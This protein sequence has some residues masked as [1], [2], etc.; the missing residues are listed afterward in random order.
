MRVKVL[1]RFELVLGAAI[2]AFNF[3]VFAHIKENAR[4]AVPDFH[5]SLFA[6]AED[7]ALWVQL[8]GRQFNGLVHDLAF[9]PW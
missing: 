8:F 7:A 9:K 5:T 3:A 4:V 1:A 6:R 2:R